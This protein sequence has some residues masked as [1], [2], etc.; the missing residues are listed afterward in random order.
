LKDVD[1]YK[2]MKTTTNVATVA[3]ITKNTTTTMTITTNL[4][5]STSS[6]V[7]GATCSDNKV[8][9]SATTTTKQYFI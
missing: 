3:M 9:F 7:V 6:G 2:T 1:T 4:S 5:L 8:V